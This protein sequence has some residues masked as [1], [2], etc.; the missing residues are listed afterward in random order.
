MM[1]QTTWIILVALVVELLNCSGGAAVAL[2][3]GINSTT[4]WYIKLIGY[5][6]GILHA[7]GLYLTD[8]LERGSYPIKP[9]DL[10]S[11]VDSSSP[12]SFANHISPHQ[13]GPR[14]PSH[15]PLLLLP[16]WAELAVLF[17]SGFLST[18]LLALI[19]SFLIGRFLQ[20]KRQERQDTAF[21]SA[22]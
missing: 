6:W 1:K 13:G 21:L 17:L 11:L 2:D 22:H 8:W 20:W 18:A 16:H 9:D 10:G 15:P 5:Q 12:N 14:P 19:I 3:P 4:P 7:P